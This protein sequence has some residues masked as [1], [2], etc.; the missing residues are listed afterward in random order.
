MLNVSRLLIPVS[1]QVAIQNTVKVVLN[2]GILSSFSVF[3][4]NI[5][6]VALLGSLE[7][8]QHPS[9]CSAPVCLSCGSQVPG[10]CT[11]TQFFLCLVEP[12]AGGF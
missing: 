7:H 9:H 3:Y 1:R 11:R 2:S 4:T 10:L 5:E 12:G 8:A 6:T